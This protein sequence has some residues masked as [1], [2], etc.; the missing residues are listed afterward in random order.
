MEDDLHRKFGGGLRVDWLLGLRC[1]A[2]VGR[3]SYHVGL[4]GR[5]A[6]TGDEW[7]SSRAG[8]GP[9]KEAP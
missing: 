6:Q 4:S 1:L 3:P 2:A 7:A 9:G 8:L 5:E